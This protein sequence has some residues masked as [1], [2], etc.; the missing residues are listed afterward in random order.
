M[1]AKYNNQT[2]SNRKNGLCVMFSGWPTFGFGFSVYF[3]KVLRRAHTYSSALI[4]PSGKRLNHSIKQIAISFLT[5]R[6]YITEYSY[7]LKPA[8]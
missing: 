1:R 4:D 6:K 7:S 8:P 3:F 5:E 2:T